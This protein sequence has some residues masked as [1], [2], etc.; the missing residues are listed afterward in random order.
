MLA[1]FLEEF[2]GHLRATSDATGEPG[3]VTFIQRFGASVR[4]VH[5]HVLALEGV[6]VRAGDGT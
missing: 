1:L 4:H 3:F 5:F 6:Y 2:T